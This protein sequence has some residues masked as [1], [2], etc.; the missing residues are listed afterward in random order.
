MYNVS[1]LPHNDI[2]FYPTPLNVA[3]ELQKNIEW[4]GV[5]NILEP[6][7]GRGDLIEHILHIREL[8]FRAKFHKRINVNQQYCIDC[9]EID[10]NLRS[11]LSGKGY[12]VVHD[13]FL[14]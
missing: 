12:R 11:I 1:K 4:R 5:K 8:E 3:Y 6:S 13:D 14:N 9:I 7:A 10:E 2:Q